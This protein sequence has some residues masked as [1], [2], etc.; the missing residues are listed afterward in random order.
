MPW[1]K[2][3][4]EHTEADMEELRN[5]MKNFG[6]PLT[7]EIPDAA[8]VLDAVKHDKKMDSGVIKFILLKKVGEAYVDRTVSREEM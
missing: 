3:H 4:R 6:L 2:T 5:V 7:V 1:H 8:E